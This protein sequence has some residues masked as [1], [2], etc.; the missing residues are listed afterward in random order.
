MQYAWSW[1]QRLRSH[2]HKIQWQDIDEA[3]RTQHRL[4]GFDY[5][6]WHSIHVHPARQEAWVHIHPSEEA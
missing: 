4:H 3:D 2:Q 5:A 6:M 1:K